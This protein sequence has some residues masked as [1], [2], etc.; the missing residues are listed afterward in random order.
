M[1]EDVL[2]PVCKRKDMPLKIDVKDGD[3]VSFD[4]R[5]YTHIV[6]CD[7]CKR[8]IKYSIKKASDGRV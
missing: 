2:C 3:S 6:F 5:E 4:L 8:K 1:R 7:N